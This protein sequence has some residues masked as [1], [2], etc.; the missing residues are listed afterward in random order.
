MMKKRR[1]TAIL[2]PTNEKGTSPNFLFLAIVSYLFKTQ[3]LQ[4]YP[5][6]QVD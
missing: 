1:K 2:R 5:H 3:I 6:H 4:G